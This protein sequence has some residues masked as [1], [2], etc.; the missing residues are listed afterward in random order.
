MA[1]MQD[2]ETVR[3]RS[4]NQRLRAELGDLRSAIEHIQDRKETEE[5]LRESEERFRLA[6]EVAGL[7]IWDYDAAA[8]KGEWSDRLREIFWL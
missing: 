8:G 4:E 6:A 5:A 7:G 2:D 1:D 3:L